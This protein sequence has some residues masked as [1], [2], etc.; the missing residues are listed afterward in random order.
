[1]LP[2]PYII[3]SKN[4]ACFKAYPLVNK[5]YAPQ[6]IA[7]IDGDQFIWLVRFFYR[8]VRNNSIGPW[9]F[10]VGNFQGHETD[11]E[12]PGIRIEHIPPNK[13]ATYQPLDLGINWQ[14]KIRYHNFL[15]GS[16]ISIINEMKHT[17]HRFKY[18]R[19]M[20]CW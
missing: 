16:S 14:A 1:M 20:V 5:S 10:I 4:L 8:E 19:T 13:T 12:L 2:M 3:K 9:L 18:N 15:R 6:S 17:N 7:L 11:V